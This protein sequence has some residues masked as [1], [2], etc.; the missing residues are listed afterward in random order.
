[1]GPIPSLIMVM[2]RAAGILT[3]DSGLRGMLGLGRLNARLRRSVT[4]MKKLILLLLA[5]N[6][7]GAFIAGCSSAEEPAADPAPADATTGE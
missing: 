3:G 4:N 6:I 2:D 7:L 5:L 1:M